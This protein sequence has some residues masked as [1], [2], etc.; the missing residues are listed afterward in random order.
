MDSMIQEMLQERVDLASS[1]L[2]ELQKKADGLDKRLAD[3]NSI[4]EMA[5]LARML[6]EVRS[7]ITHLEMVRQKT[8]SQLDDELARIK[9]SDYKAAVKKMDQIEIDTEDQAKTIDHKMY[10]LLDQ[11]DHLRSTC[12]EYDTLHRQHIRTYSSY[13][14]MARYN[15][16]SMLEGKLYSIQHD[17]VYQMRR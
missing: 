12:K 13:S 11:I 2:T 5:E 7:D 17:L 14:L 10:D 8:L 15:W 4:E 16:I 6:T 3:A 9:S 1:R